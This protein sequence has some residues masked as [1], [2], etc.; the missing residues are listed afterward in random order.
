MRMLANIEF[1]MFAHLFWRHYKV[2]WA[3]P[4]ILKLFCEATAY[5]ERRLAD[6]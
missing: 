1:R 4:S 3:D 2:K 6:C 5:I